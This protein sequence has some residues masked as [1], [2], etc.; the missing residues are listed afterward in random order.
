MN[1]VFKRI[2]LYGELVMFSHTLFSMPFALVAVMLAARGLPDFHTGE[3]ILVALISARTCANALNRV[4]DRH[5][6]ARNHRTANRHM[7]QG[8]VAPAE[9][10]LFTFVGLGIF[11]YAAFQLNPLCVM[12][13]PLPVSL[14]FLYSYTKRFTW[15]CHLILGI[16]CAGAPVGAWIAVTGRFDLVPLVM[17]AAVALWIAGFDVIYGAQDVDFDRQE[18]LY[19]I[20]AVFGVRNALMI[21]SGMHL[22]TLLFL[23]GMG[24]LVPLHGAYYVGLALIGGLLFYE[25]RLVSP[26]NLSQVKIASYSINQ[27]VGMI[28]FFFTTIDIFLLK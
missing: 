28:F 2:R 10:M 5:I 19:S 8:L 15:L 7:P 11:V 24:V 18:K 3:W 1:W 26:D 22:L 14:F 9:V 12:L 4:V 6:D 21:S 20:P 27:I 23:V 13:L 25:H 17:G 16:T